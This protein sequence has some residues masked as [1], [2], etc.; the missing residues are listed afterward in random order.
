MM[1]YIT[2]SIFSALLI[3]SHWMSAQSNSI[4]GSIIDSKG[5]A[6]PFV[7]V[8][9]LSRDSTTKAVGTSDAK[10]N[11]MV[12]MSTANGPYL[13]KISFIGYTTHFQKIQLAGADINVGK[14]TLEESLTTLKSINV[15]S[16]KKAQQ[17]NIDKTIITADKL[18]VADGGNAT[19]VLRSAPAVTVD[20]D[21]NVA[22]RG[23]KNVAILING[24]PATR[25]GGDIRKVLQSMPASN[26]ESVEV[27]NN[28]SAK[29]RAE[30]SSGVI[31]IITKKKKKPGITGSLELN[32]TANPDANGEAQVGYMNS[33]FD[34]NANYS[35]FLWNG[36]PTQD[37]KTTLASLDT[38]FYFT[39]KYKGLNQNINHNGGLNLGFN[40]DSNQ[41]IDVG[42]WINNF[43]G[44]QPNTTTNNFYTLSDKTTPFYQTMGDNSTGWNGVFWG[45]YFNHN[46]TGKKGASI[47]TQLFYS[48]GKFR[49]FSETIENSMLNSNSS[50]LTNKSTSAERGNDFDVSIDYSVPLS[51]AHTLELGFASDNDL[52]VSNQHYFNYNN[53]IADFYEIPAHQITWKYNLSINGAYATINGA[54]EKWSYKMGLRAEQT[55][56]KGMIV[57]TTKEINGDY[58]SFFP[59]IHLNYKSKKDDNITFSYSRRINRPENWQLSPWSFNSDTRF[60][61]KGNANLKP[62]I[63][64]SY[65]ISYAK[66]YKKGSINTSFYYRLKEHP[67]NTINY[68]DKDGIT[69]DML[70]NINIA[71]NLGLDLSF[72]WSPK[73][74]FSTT[75]NINPRYELVEENHNPNY[76]FYDY[77]QADMNLMMNFNPTKWWMIQIQYGF[78]PHQKFLQ[79]ILKSNQGLDIAMR[80]KLLKNK[81][82]ITAKVTDIFFT[83]RYAGQLYANNLYQEF[84]NKYQSRVF[85]VGV[86]YRFGMDTGRNKEENL[87]RNNNGGGGRSA[88]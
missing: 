71:H 12:T 40:L 66:A 72:Q 38:S 60:R 25:Y 4:R 65:D 37:I 59:T 5:A 67:F 55:D 85:T 87:L 58:I 36:Y 53:E 88:R 52:S 77:L 62:E 51:D 30:G 69:Y 19:D 80:F 61:S 47:A 48:R 1:K 79:G 31:N 34:M 27:V 8:F 49:G 63:I 22:L 64:N 6:L 9:L 76:K 68:T 50:P 3:L 43:V 20:I 56:Y 16:E 44:K 13:L 32:A 17:N 7:N 78:S 33:T 18:A 28:P 81:F 75:L 29:Y 54:Y 83:R 73:K 11:F 21:G 84:S 2:I 45:A 74:W 82:S 57:N 24:V 41:R 70:S 39:T 10:G 15:V 26:I 86:Q 46:Y 42:G 35:Y 14:I 23:D